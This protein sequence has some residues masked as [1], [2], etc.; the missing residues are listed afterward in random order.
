MCSVHY[1]ENFTSCQLTRKMKDIY[2]GTLL[3]IMMILA[4][5]TSFFRLKK[6]LFSPVRPWEVQYK[7]CV[8]KSL[9]THE[10]FFHYSLFYSVKN[11]SLDIATFFGFYLPLVKKTRKS[12]TLL[13]FRGKYLEN[14][15]SWLCFDNFILYLKTVW[16]FRCKICKNTVARWHK[17]WS[18]WLT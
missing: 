7:I 10:A 8:L 4:G 9:W 17:T 13:I 3:M 2:I 1:E 12:G 5:L 15:H 16:Y 6:T 18:L 11:S 14:Q